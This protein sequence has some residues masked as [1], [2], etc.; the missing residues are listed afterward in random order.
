[1]TYET[2]GSK[3]VGVLSVSHVIVGPDEVWAETG[4]R[5]LLANQTELKTVIAKRSINIIALEFDI[6][7]SGRPDSI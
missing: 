2:C 3:K 1:M 6:M 7:V 5:L 4:G